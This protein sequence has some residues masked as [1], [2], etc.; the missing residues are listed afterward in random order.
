MPR[1]FFPYVESRDKG[2]GIV[3]KELEMKRQ[4]LLAGIIALSLDGSQS[5]AEI[6]E[7]LWTPRISQ[8]TPR[9]AA[10]VWTTRRDLRW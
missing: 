10:A 9:I 6:R 4:L 1:G 7:M 3:V 5:R 8:P 2:I